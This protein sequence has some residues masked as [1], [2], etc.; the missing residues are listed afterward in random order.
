MQF[1]ETIVKNNT[2]LNELQDSKFEKI[3]SRILHDINSP[4][5]V[6]VQTTSALP[7]EERDLATRALNRILKII[8]Y[9][10]YNQTVYQLNLVCEW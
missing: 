3:R 10:F 1:I 4:I 5:A 9:D 8:S 2:F 6:L 7:F